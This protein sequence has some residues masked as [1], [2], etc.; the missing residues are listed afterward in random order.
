MPGNYGRCNPKKGMNKTPSREKKNKTMQGESGLKPRCATNMQTNY[1]GSMGGHSGIKCVRR[2]VKIVS[3]LLTETSTQIAKRMSFRRKTHSLDLLEVPA[4]TGLCIRRDRKENR[5]FNG[6]RG[7]NMKTERVVKANG[8]KR[9]IEQR[10]KIS[11]HEVH[12]GSG[13]PVP[14][15]HRLRWSLGLEG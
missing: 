1:F 7:V 8:D 3:K 13:I 11:D 10:S 5:I 15:S 12:H 14:Y 2:D 6:A 4:T 9:R